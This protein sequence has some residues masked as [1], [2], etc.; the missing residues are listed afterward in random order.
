MRVHMPL[1]AQRISSN[2]YSIVKV[3]VDNDT[4]PLTLYKAMQVKN[5]KVVKDR[6]D[7]YPDEVST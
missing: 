5:W 7:L 6:M 2:D 1:G 3:L 4:N